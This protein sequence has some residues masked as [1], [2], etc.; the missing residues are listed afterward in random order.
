MN[1]KLSAIAAAVAAATLSATAGAAAVDF[2]GYFRSGI[3][4]TSEGGK[5][6]CV[7]LNGA[8]A[9]YRLGNEC[10]TYGELQ[11]DSNL[12]DQNDT[13]VGITIMEAFSVPQNG[14]WEQS[15]G[16]WRQAYAHVTGLGAGPLATAQAWV[17]K[18]YYKRRDIHLIDF[19]YS[20][21]TGPGA[22]I[23]DIDLGFGKLSYAMLRKANSD[24]ETQTSHDFRLEGIQLYPNGSLDLIAQLSSKNN[25]DPAGANNKNGY[26]FTAQHNQ[27]NI[28]GK[29]WNQ[30]IVQF[31][32]KAGNLDG[33]SGPSTNDK[34]AFRVIDHFFF[35]F[36]AIDGEG[37]ALYQKVKK[38]GGKDET[39][40]TIGARPVYHF[41]DIYSL[42]TE[43]GYTQTKVA[44]EE[45]KNLW[46]ATLAGQI[47]A[48]KS[49][50]SRPT[51][52][53]FVTYNKWNKAG[54]AYGTDSF[55]ADATNGTTYG[56]QTEAWW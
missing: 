43:V 25:V 15:A 49:Y 8:W 31:A 48:G 36:G 18:R 17:G 5:Q 16:S 37:V 3:G 56:F 2:H 21:N 34:S 42:A 22:G 44:G 40:S 14:D 53:A 55:G 27:N 23:A 26:S 46:K 19:F 51:L 11:L 38:E 24:V 6:A 33:S 7:G 45:S 54:N 41:S 52:R 4:S 39:W 47:S 29:G 50:W 10:E 30:F 9:K 20:A 35:G 13:K 12:Y 32:D 28:F 1:F